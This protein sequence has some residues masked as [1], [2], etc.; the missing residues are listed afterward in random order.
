M[1]DPSG[2][3]NA[4]AIGVWGLAPQIPVYHSTSLRLNQGIKREPSRW[5][6][7]RLQSILL[8][9]QRD[10]HAVGELDLAILA[11]DA[12]DGHGLI[13]AGGQRGGRHREGRQGA[14]RHVR[15]GPV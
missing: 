7:S 3:K 10:G 4:A 6:G 2:T 5:E 13:L 8:H 11:I 9:V 15:R 1:A 12:G 14:G